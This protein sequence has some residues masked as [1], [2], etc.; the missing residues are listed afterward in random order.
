GSVI[1]T[2]GEPV[3][4]AVVICNYGADM[5]PVRGRTDADGRFELTG[6][7]ARGTVTILAATEDGSLAYAQPVDPSVA[8]E[9]V[10]ELFPPP[11]LAVTVTGETDAIARARARAGVER[12][13][14]RFGEL[15]QGL[16][17]SV[18]EIELDEEGRFRVD[19]LIPGLQYRVIAYVGELRPD[20]VELIAAEQVM[21]H[22]GEE[23]IELSLKLMTMAEFAAQQG[24]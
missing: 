20:A 1:D 10:F 19:G 23:T 21:V 17:E 2:E 8:L 4:G 14:P 18:E 6:L 5:N 11:S 24:R 7:S 9:P 15:P 12:S 13:G 3:E 16:T 22:G